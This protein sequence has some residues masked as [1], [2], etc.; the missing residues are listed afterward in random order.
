ME[1]LIF[2][3]AT[4]F[5]I[6]A[7]YAV[8][9]RG[10]FKKLQAEFSEREVFWSQSYDNQR[11]EIAFLEQFAVI[12]PVTQFLNQQ[13]FQLL[14]Y[15]EQ[16]RLLLGQKLVFC[17]IQVCCVMQSNLEPVS[18]EN[19][20]QC[21]IATAEILRDQFPPYYGIGHLGGGTF[22]LVVP[23]GLTDPMVAFQVAHVRGSISND[24][25]FTVGVE[26]IIHIGI[27]DSLQHARDDLNRDI[28][29]Q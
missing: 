11:L 26:T 2:L 21:V 28:G 15:K 27:G 8:Q 1:L 16:S 13:G 25:Q 4:V 7:G 23:P 6:T 19:V 20:S 29:T 18:S 12:D 5:V 10:S 9:I 14:I 22:A 17:V 24:L 3:W